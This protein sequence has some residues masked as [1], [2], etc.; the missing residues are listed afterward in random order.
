VSIKN[1]IKNKRPTHFTVNNIEV[2]IKDGFLNKDID[3]KR[4]VTK[5]L[6]RIP[7]HLYNNVDSIYVGQFDFLKSMKMSASYQD[8][9][10]FLSNEQE[11]E[12]DIYDDII[13]EIG[14]AVEETYSS[15][16]YADRLIE[17]EF[18]L[19]RKRFK[20]DLRQSEIDVSG[21]DFLNVEYDV[22][23]DKFLYSKVGYDRV[24][25]IT[26]SYYMSPYSVT[27]IREY[28]AE[29]FEKFYEG[30]DISLIKSMHPALYQKIV[31]LTTGE[32][33]EI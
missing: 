15:F 13:H 29:A 2:F 17:K 3:F 7:S 22:E 31:K 25:S 32:Q 24:R 21:Y 18:L 14:H 16:V 12:Q 11:D 28:F 9:A 26:S 19:K 20:R 4:T 1:Y 5:T 8:S 30:G 27:S 23:F 6:E 33:D 10:I